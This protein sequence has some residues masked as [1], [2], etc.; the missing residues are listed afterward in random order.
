MRIE[1]AAEERH[2]RS[3]AR[4]RQRAMRRERDRKLSEGVKE[5]EEDFVPEMVT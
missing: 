2:F 3:S 4:I 5:E 1:P